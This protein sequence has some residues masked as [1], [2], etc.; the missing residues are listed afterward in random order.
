MTQRSFYWM[1]TWNNPGPSYSQDIQG[2]PDVKYSVYQLE[3]GANGTEHVQ[4]YAIFVNKK[5]R[6][7]VNDHCVAARGNSARGAMSRQR[8]M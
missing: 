2:W 3:Q 4:G 1:F 8:R 5:Q 6:K 7:W